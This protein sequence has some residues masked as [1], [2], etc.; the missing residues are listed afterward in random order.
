MTR[1]EGPEKLR[2]DREVMAAAAVVVYRAF[3][4]RACGS[5]RRRRDR[6]SVRTARLILVYD[7]RAREKRARHRRRESRVRLSGEVG[8]RG[9][10][11]G[12]GTAHG[13][14]SKTAARLGSA[15]YFLG[16]QWACCTK[17]RRGSRICS[18]LLHGFSVSDLVQS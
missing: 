12:V 2:L 8:P 4:Y 14:I 11:R 15:P 7:A 9:L 18:W 5:S 3:A 1:C 16:F 10:E 17:V 6:E 13:P